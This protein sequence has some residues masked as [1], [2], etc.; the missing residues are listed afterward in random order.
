M[1]GSQGGPAGDLYVD[2]EVAQDPRFERD[3]LDLVTRAHVSLVEAALGG[4]VHL[5]LPDDTAVDVDIPSGTQPGDVITVKSR[6]APRLDGRGK[7][8][9]QIVMQVEIPKTLSPRAK[10]LLRELEADLEKHS[11]KQDRSKAEKTA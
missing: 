5:D 1:A 7:G 11:P 3:G 9:L 4:S 6:G 8:S 10:E 2:I